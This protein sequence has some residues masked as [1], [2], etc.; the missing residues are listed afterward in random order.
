MTGGRMRRLA[1]LIFLGALTLR[2]ELLPIRVYTTADGLAADRVDRIVADS[3]GFLWFCTQEGVSRFDGTRF[4]SYRP[5]QGLPHAWVRTLIETRSGEHWI[6]TAEGL[7]RVASDG[8]GPRFTNYRLGADPAANRISALLEARSGKFWVGAKGGLFEW[9]DPLHFRRMN[10]P[11]PPQLVN[12]MAEDASGNLLIGT[13]TGVYIFRDNRIVQNVSSKDG[14]PGTWVEMFLWDS[15]GR[16]WVALR[17]GLALMSRGP[18][19]AWS[20]EKV[21]TER[22]GLVAGGVVAVLEASDGTL[23]VGTN[24]GISRLIPGSGV[25]QNLTRAQGLSDRY[26]LSLAEDQAGNIWAGTEGAGVMRISGLGFKSYREQDGLPTDRVMSVFEDRGGEPVTVTS[27]PQG[28]LSVNTFDGKRFHSVVPKAFGDNPGWGWN[29]VLLQSRTGEWWAA[30]NAGICRFGAMKAAELDG[31]KP[32]ACY[33]TGGAMVFRIFEDSQGRIWAGGQI[34]DGAWMLGYLMRWDPE[35]NA[36]THFPNPPNPGEPA[37]DMASAFAEDRQGNVWIGLYSGGLYRYNGRKIQLFRKGDGV[38]GGGIFA[39]LADKGGLWI[40]SD[41]AGLGRIENTGDDHPRIEI[42]NTDRGMA[43]NLIF[44]L[45][46]DL[47]GRIYA[48]TGQGV[49]RLDP[50]NGHIRHFSTFDGLAHGEFT[51]AA[52][53][54]S[55]SL[56]FSTKQGV[57]RLIPAPDPPPVVPR[58]LITDLRVGGVPYPVSQL[59]ETRVSGLELKPSQNQLQVEFVGL[60]YEPGASVRY[61]Y[62]LEGASSTWSPPRNQNTVNYDALSGAKYRFLVKAVTSEGVESGAPAEIDFTVLPPVWKRW[63]FESLAL[64]LVAA[65]VFAA[66]RYRV[67][68][69]M[70]LERMRTAIATDLHDDIGASLSQIAI[71]SEVARV[72]GNGE[73]R[74][75]EPLERV[76]TLARELVDSMGDIVWSIRSEP[77]GLDSLVRRMREFALDVLGSQGIEFELRTSPSG[78]TIQLSLQTRRELFLIFKECIHNVSRHSACTAVKAVLKVL[79]REIELTVE[80]NGRGLNPAGKP[81][82]STG[83]NGIPGMRSRAESLGGRM[84]LASKPGEGCAVAIHLPRRR[85]AFA[86]SRL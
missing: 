32:Q 44:C 6:G 27:T 40:G 26:I 12:D 23:W 5:D 37:T 36:I 57:S 70:R 16:L 18:T 59:G 82:G 83:G 62:M 9:T 17:G 48:G 65:L 24:E 53:D 43:S 56:W 55:G 21:Y 33:S 78:E 50:R 46:E 85:G 22:S 67:T 76:A 25:F 4:V 69:M 10:F 47:Q 54:R 2:G 13:T 7:S 31:K 34:W 84:Q 81:P 14:L 3:R 29:Q 72:G 60:D 71:L 42:Y 79:D 19:G 61:S 20:I 51:A 86:K 80:D 64:A 28:G 68:Q 58:I 75:G 35:T 1:I 52:R 15:K 11:T 73:G 45:V 8:Y 49:D 63:W 66:H 39:L 74:P 30:T 41:G 77:H 38:P